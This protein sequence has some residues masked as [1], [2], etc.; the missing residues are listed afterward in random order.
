VVDVSR[1]FSIY[2]VVGLL[3]IVLLYSFR[4]TISQ[5]TFNHR[6]MVR[7]MSNREAVARTTTKMRRWKCSKGQFSDR[8]P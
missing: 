1:M 6:Q 5:T 2:F 4:N 8:E 3:V 7:R